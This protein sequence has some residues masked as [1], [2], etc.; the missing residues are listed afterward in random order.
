M[1]QYHGQSPDCRT[2]RGPAIPSPDSDV[3]DLL[4]LQTASLCLHSNELITLQLG[5]LGGPWVSVSKHAAT[6]PPALQAGPHTVC[7]CECVVSKPPSARQASRRGWW[8]RWG[9][10]AGA[11]TSLSPFWGT[12]VIRTG[13]PSQP[14]GSAKQPQ[15]RSAGFPQAIAGPY[16]G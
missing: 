4:W 10:T 8:R 5:A 16:T 6:M 2:S 15:W 3:R 12:A 14:Q 1:K 11:V 13:E 7:R 9:S